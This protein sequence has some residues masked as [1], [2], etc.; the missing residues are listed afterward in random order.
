M[1]LLTKVT[2]ALSGLLVHLIF[3]PTSAKVR[4]FLKILI[5]TA[6]QNP[7]GRAWGK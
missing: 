5:V 4:E 7:Y 2:N 6:A 3:R 1:Y